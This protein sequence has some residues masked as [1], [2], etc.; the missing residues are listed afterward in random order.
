MSKSVKVV[1]AACILHNF[2]RSKTCTTQY[3]T[4]L[5]HTNILDNHHNN[6]NVNRNNHIVN[7]ET[8][9]NV[10]ENFVDFFNR[11]YDDATDDDATDD[12]AYILIVT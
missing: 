9:Q 2:L 12:D 5:Y 8:G 1:K 4:K 10:R 3:L 6:I 11:V 7:R